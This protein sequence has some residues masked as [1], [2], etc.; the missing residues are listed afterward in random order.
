[1]I[2]ARSARISGSPPV[3]RTSRT[4]RSRTPMPTRRAI[5]AGGQ[6]VV[7]RD[8]G[9]PL[10]R[11]AV[12]AAQRALL[13]DRDPQVARRR[14]RSGRAGPDASGR[15]SVLGGAVAPRRLRRIRAAAGVP[16][17]HG[18]SPS[19]HRPA[20]TPTTI[21]FSHGY[22]LVRFPRPSADRRPPPP[23]RSVPDR[24]LP[25]ALRRARPRASP[26]TTGS[27][28]SPPRTGDVHRWTWDEFMALP[29]EDV[30]TDIH[31]VTSWSKLGTSLARRRSS[32]PCST[33][34]DTS[35]EYT[36]AHSYGGYT[37]NVPLADLLG[38]Q[39]LGRAPVRR[40][41]PRPR[42]R[43]PRAPAGAAPV[44]LE[45]RQVGRRPR[46]CCRQRRAR[47]LGAERL[48]HVRRPVAGTALLVSSRLASWP[49]SSPYA[50]GDPDGPHPPPARP[51]PARATS[52]VSTST[53]G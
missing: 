49:M 23:T 12:G 20:G 7:A 27:S 36:M 33:D 10:R 42:A 13:G 16:D 28:P 5:S 32:T 45:E 26:K 44:L 15:P 43:R 48:Q 24:G 1:M 53:S 47:L 18:A 21:S 52:P 6:Q 37:T 3:N 29:Q 30:G 50:H 17:L 9:Q 2:S 8:R 39:G 25:R 31:C 38:R 51:G 35:C 41:R 46:R 14:G 4:P 11:H 22:H 19:H 34:V 40:Q